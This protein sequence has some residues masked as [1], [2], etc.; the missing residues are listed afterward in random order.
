MRLII[1]A[2][3]TS[4]RVKSEDLSHILKRGYQRNFDLSKGSDGKNGQPRIKAAFFGSLLKNGRRALSICHLSV[5]FLFVDRLLQRVSFQRLSC[6]FKRPPNG[7]LVL[8]LISS[9]F[10]EENTQM[11][12][13]FKNVVQ[14]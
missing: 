2:T 12:H 1:R 14:F 8:F 10:I 9:I 13:L 4:L 11:N 6:V 7:V 5:I 3:S